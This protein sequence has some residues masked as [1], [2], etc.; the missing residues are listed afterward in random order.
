[1]HRKQQI[2]EHGFI[3]LQYIW[4]PVITEFIVSCYT[5]VI[6]AWCCTGFAAWISWSLLPS[7]ALPT[8]TQEFSAAEMGWCLEWDRSTFIRW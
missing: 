4:L 6:G 3:V 7:A 5:Y 2:E 8:R 1:V